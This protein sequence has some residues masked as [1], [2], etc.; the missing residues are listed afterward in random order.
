M[1]LGIFTTITKPQERGDDYNEA[2]R[3]YKDLADIVTVIDGADTWPQEFDWPVIGQHFQKGYDET[4]A[5]FVIHADIDF[6][7]H[8]QDMENIRRTLERYHK[9]PMV[10]FL[11][12]QFIQPHKYNLKS[13]LPLAVNK[14]M[15]GDRIKFNGGGDLCQPTLD[16]VYLNLDDIPQTKI[17]VYNYEKLSK[18]RQQIEDDV[19]RMDR[20]Y[21]RHF[22]KYLYSRDGTDES[23]YE[24]WW[25][26]VSG[27]YNKPQKEISLVEHPKY[28]RD[29]IM[30]LKPDQFGY[31]GFGTMKGGYRA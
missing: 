29:T 7:F 26:M 28:I 16:G 15:F 19:G 6:F 17:P 13:R 8:E 31:D 3:C 10:S 11:K 21:H 14:K 20:A 9:Y 1:R 2:I 22:G 18:T 24:G 23:A 25:R 12:W 5:D 27:R 30:N 4:E